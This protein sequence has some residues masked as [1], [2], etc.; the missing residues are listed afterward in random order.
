MVMAEI[1]L[2]IMIYPKEWSFNW[3]EFVLKIMQR[4]IFLSEFFCVSFFTTGIGV[5]LFRD[6]KAKEAFEHF[7]RAIT[8]Y[9]RNIEAFVARGALW[10]YR[11]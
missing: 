3:S 9:P 11:F 2:G 1:S 7:D 8:L 10:V 6:G 5:Q 4:F